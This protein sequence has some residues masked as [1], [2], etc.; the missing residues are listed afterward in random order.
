MLSQLQQEYAHLNAIDFS[1]NEQGVIFIH[2]E[3]Q[4]ACATISL[5]GGHVCHFQPQG[6]KPLLWMSQSASFQPGKAIR[7]GVPVCWPWFGPHPKGLPQHGF[8]RNQAW[9]LAGIERLTDG[10]IKVVL[11]VNQSPAS[12]QIWPYPFELTLSLVIGTELDMVLTS[13]NTGDTAFTVG[14]ALH[15]YFAIADIARTRIEGLAETVFDDKVSGEEG[16]IQLGDIL[17]DQ[18]VDRVYLD[19]RAD[20]LIHDEG[21]GRVIRVTKSG[22]QTTVVWNPWLDKAA[23]MVDFDDQG[24]GQMLCIEAV[25]AGQDVYS[26]KPNQEHILRQKVGICY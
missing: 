25:N 24:Y 14:G 19:A 11:S 18:E 26:L 8:V 3:S 17:I 13:K 7:G 15:S 5:H 16:M 1:Q 23:S 10:Q 2:V 21:N 20:C 12:Q 6:E 4:L 9:Q 22:S